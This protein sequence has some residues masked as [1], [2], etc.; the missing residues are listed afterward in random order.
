MV[1]ERRVLIKASYVFVVCSVSCFLRCSPVFTEFSFIS[2]P[3]LPRRKTLSS[4]V[5]GRLVRRMSCRT[6]KRVALKTTLCSL[7]CFQG[8]S[9]KSPSATKMHINGILFALCMTNHVC[10]VFL[11]QDQNFLYHFLMMFRWQNK[12]F[13]SNLLKHKEDFLQQTCYLK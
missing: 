5:K 9:L 11:G 1:Q 10:K 3:L 8:H 13:I 6:L 12:F 7:S 2:A 4:K